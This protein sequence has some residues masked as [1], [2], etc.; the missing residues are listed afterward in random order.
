MSLPTYSHFGEL[1]QSVLISKSQESEDFDQKDLSKYFPNFLWLMRDCD[2]EIT[3]KEGKE[4]SPTEY[5][6]SEIL[7][8]TNTSEN[9]TR[10]NIVNSIKTSFPKIECWRIPTPGP[11]IIQTPPD[12]RTI[13]P[14]FFKSLNTVIEHIL[15]SI[16]P[17]R[18][19][20]TEI[21]LTGSMLATMLEE[22]VKA[23]N[24]SGTVPNLEESYQ[25]AVVV[26]LNSLILRLYEEY[27]RD[28]SIR[29]EGLL[30]IEEGDLRSLEISHQTMKAQ[31][32]EGNLQAET[33]TTD[34]KNTLFQIHESVFSKYL[35]QL[36]AEIHKLIPDILTE[37]KLRDDVRQ[38]KLCLLDQFQQLI[39]A[40]ENG[41]ICRGEFC[42][43][44]QLNNVKSRDAC[45]KLFEKIYSDQERKCL[46]NISN[47]HS[48]YFKNAVGPAKDTVYHDLIQHIPAQ[49][50]ELRVSSS[51]DQSLTLSWK[52]SPIYPHAATAYDILCLAEEDSTPTI[53][54]CGAANQYIIKGLKAKTQYSIKVRGVNSQE[55]KHGEF[56]EPLISETKPGKPGKPS[57]PVIIPDTDSIGR[58]LVTMLPKEKENGSPV[59]NINV[60]CRNDII[61]SWRYVQRPV[62]PA[63]GDQQSLK[64]DIR[65]S[66]D[67]KILW[68]RIQFVNEAKL[69][70]E[71]SETVQLR[72]ANMIPG[73]P[74]NFR[75]KK[76]ARQ[77]T[78]DWD[79]PKNNP[80]A[81]KLYHIQYWEKK[82]D[83]K[84]V[85]PKD[86]TVEPIE[87]SLIINNL[88]PK[89]EYLI[90]IYAKNER[91]QYSEY[92]TISIETLPDVPN[93]PTLCDVEIV[94]ANQAV[95]TIHKQSKEEQNGSKVEKLIIE[96]ATRNIRQEA[97]IVSKWTIQEM[98]YPAVT[99]Q[100]NV[101]VKVN[102]V[103]LTDKVI[104][105][106]RIRTQNSIGKSEP[107]QEYNLHPEH[108]IPG[109][110]ESLTYKESEITNNTIVLLWETPKLHP[111]AVSKYLVNY[112]A[113]N[114]NSWLSRNIESDLSKSFCAKVTDLKPNTEYNFSVEAINL[115]GLHSEK[116]S[117]SVSTLPSVPP[118]PRPPLPRPSGSEFVLKTYLPAVEESGR[119]VTT[120][121]VNT[122]SINDTT[123]PLAIQTFAINPRNISS[124]RSNRVYEQQ[125][126]INVDQ[127]SWLS[128]ILENEI[129][130]SEESDLV[131]VT[132]GNVTP[133]APDNVK[134]EVQ[135]RSSTVT[136]SVP[137]NNGNAAKYYEV[138]V[139]PL[140]C[141]WERQDN[142]LIQQ[143][144]SNDII[145]YCTSITGLIPFKAYQFG[146]QAVND[147]AKPPLV[148]KRTVTPCVETKKDVPEKPTSPTIVD[149]E[150]M[151]AE[152]EIIIKP[153]SEDQMNG[154][155]VDTVIIDCNNYYESIGT[156]FELT[157][158]EKKEAIILRRKIKLPNLTDPNINTYWFRVRMK[159]EIGESESSDPFPLPASKLQPGPPIGLEILKSGITPHTMEVSW[160]APELHPALVSGYTLEYSLVGKKKHSQNFGR[161]TKCYV[162]EGL[163][164]SQ[165]YMIKLATRTLAG[166]SSIPVEATAST[167]AIYPSK[168]T[169]LY[170][171]RKGIDSAKFRWHKPIENP[172][173]VEFYHVELRE[174]D[175]VKA[176][177]LADAKQSNKEKKT[178]KYEAK[179]SHK[180]I[181]NRRTIGHSTVFDQL[182]SRTTY[183]VCVS[184]FNDNK[185]MEAS[186]ISYEAFTTKMS[187]GLRVGLQV[188]SSPTIGGAVALGYAQAPDTN[189][190]ASDEEFLADKDLYPSSPRE[191]TVTHVKKN[192][193]KLEWKPPRINSVELCYYKVELVPAADH[194]EKPVTQLC[195]G[196]SSYLDIPPN[197]KY[198]VTVTSYNYYKKVDPNGASISL[199]KVFHRSE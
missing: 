168:P 125:L 56:S 34:R 65:C 197:I 194:S 37:G 113:A 11:G 43:F 142:C 136:W 47:L 82:T 54:Q 152:I 167:Q 51:T 23:L 46:V 27:S 60:G 55:K 12:R 78:V 192:N 173:E 121:R 170:V 187:K 196:T 62:D 28:I 184:A 94:S 69:T 110:P 178:A 120:L 26:S 171:D 1:S 156:Y 191:L 158:E 135:A 145:S 180:I 166:K 137:Q 118:K 41:K 164:S 149:E 30:P 154:S 177:K 74:E 73:K 50:L 199:C 111:K 139:K 6:H 101:S 95:L 71:P 33:N 64:V 105:L 80:M 44:V 163:Q 25:T 102:L 140:H 116:S 165:Q 174:G 119:E 40:F 36:T 190:E 143:T 151:S 179:E 83:Q 18:G 193:F 53:W 87:T 114:E 45:I 15:S 138:F 100:R 99:S 66:K 89:S 22:Y 10:D 112:K 185:K 107:S 29:L 157:K 133:G 128:I 186:A 117:L 81:V 188:L 130:P 160:K 77:I 153:L 86:R 68:F 42:Q 182:K 39:V 122:Y 84:Q 7:V 132:S 195:Y 162:I 109:N 3:D 31:S 13:N 176:L 48:E 124:Q 70:S 90:R 57:T 16:T 129:G 144:R 106:Y 61:T 150:S 155:S 146:V 52:P 161:E 198:S 104:T 24:T 32:L 9:T 14:A 85:S 93:K 172:K 103:S 79:P 76:K 91:S 126:K 96:Q 147:T 141:D 97:L 98:K 5:I 49:P 21:P 59:T 189:I 17:K 75:G 88:I 38:K 115:R 134:V 35:Q 148:G 72:A 19:F 58:L 183:T 181:R 169:S 67:V 127:I 108:F 4:M 131:G 123:D 92:N 20:N 175:F 2:L 63:Q 8:T 159:N